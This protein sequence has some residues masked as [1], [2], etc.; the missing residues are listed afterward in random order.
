MN[1]NHLHNLPKG[2]RK[3]VHGTACYCGTCGAPGTWDD[4]QH[5]EGGAAIFEDA[6]FYN[7]F[8]KHIEC[9][10]CWLK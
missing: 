1:N 5:A 10:E 4:M 7:T 6:C 3:L 8:E 9:H 2:S